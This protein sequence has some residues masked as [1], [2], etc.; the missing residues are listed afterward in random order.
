MNLLF[1]CS[2]NQWRSPTAERVVRGWGP[3]F[4]ARSAGTSPQARVRVSEKAMAWADVVF[5]ME[6][7]HREL[8]RER[9]GAAARAREIVVLDIPDQ[10]QADD[11]ELVAMLDRRV[12]EELTQRDLWPDEAP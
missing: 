5:V 11:P 7:R 10:W 12:R 8:L 1:V 2:R 3:P 4:A 6:A 9:F